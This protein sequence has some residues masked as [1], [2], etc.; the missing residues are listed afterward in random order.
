MDHAALDYAVSLAERIDRDLRAS[1]LAPSRA[2]AASFLTSPVPLS[3]YCDCLTPHYDRS[4][5][6]PK[7]MSKNKPRKSINV[8]AGRTA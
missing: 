1:Q 8:A 7:V 2:T 4:Q 6:Q 5:I 3:S